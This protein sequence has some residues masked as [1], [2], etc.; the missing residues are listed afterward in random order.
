MSL[1]WVAQT[2]PSSVVCWV[3]HQPLCGLLSTLHSSY[4]SHQCPLQRTVVIVLLETIP[5]HHYHRPKGA[6]LLLQELG[7]EST[8]KRT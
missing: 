5:F 8:G 2:K 3:A 7:V 1:Q 4:M 6:C